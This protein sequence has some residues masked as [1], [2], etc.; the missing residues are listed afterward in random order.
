[1]KGKSFFAQLR[2]STLKENTTANN[3]YFLIIVI[4]NT[5]QQKQPHTH[6]LFCKL[7]GYLYFLCSSPVLRANTAIIYLPTRLSFPYPLSTNSQRLLNV[8]F[9]QKSAWNTIIEIVILLFCKEGYMVYSRSQFWV[10]ISFCSQL[11]L[12]YIIWHLAD[13]NKRRGLNTYIILC[14]FIVTSH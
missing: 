2:I 6:F 14:A 11:F 5:K 9:L 7:C 8:V 1:M 3:V 13:G 12:H 4:A 10:I